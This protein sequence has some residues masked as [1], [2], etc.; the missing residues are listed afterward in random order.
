MNNIRQKT[1]FDL[2]GGELKNIYIRISPKKDANPSVEGWY[3]FNG[4]DFIATADTEVNENKSYFEKRILNYKSISFG[5]EKVFKLGY[6]TNDN[7]GMNY[8]IFLRFSTD[9]DDDPDH[10]F[11]IGKTGMFEFQPEEWRDVND[12]DTERTAE[13]FVTEL[14][15]FEDVPFVVDYCYSV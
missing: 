13:V 9:Q 14:K 4:S 1:N 6:C 3:E 8:P 5:D 2:I 11:Q 15:V 12:D 7:E 10:E